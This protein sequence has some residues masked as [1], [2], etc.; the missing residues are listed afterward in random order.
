MKQQPTEDGRI[1]PRHS[2]L[3]R[4][5]LAL[6]AEIHNRE[7]SKT[8][9]LTYE[10]AFSDVP[11]EDL[12]GALKE[13]IRTVEF[14][15]T[16]GHIQRKLDDLTSRKVLE[17]SSS[18]YDAKIAREDSERLMEL[19]RRANQ[20]SHRVETDTKEERIAYANKLLGEVDKV[21]RAKGFTA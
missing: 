11:Y 9:I 12:R 8:M 3:I 21:A 19:E 14:W 17:K 10:A 1:T 13:T 7:L 18:E 15:P 5:F 16:P 4:K 6:M 2:A 20:T